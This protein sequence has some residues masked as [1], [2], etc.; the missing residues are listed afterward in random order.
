MAKNPYDAE[1]LNDLLLQM[2]ETELGGE[3]VYLT[4]LRCA[5]NSDLQ[6]EWQ[7]YLEQTKM[8]Q[9]V[10]K[11]LCEGVGLDPNTQT[12]SRKVVKHIGD[13]LVQAME[14]ALQG[15]SP[16]AAELVACECVVHAETKDHANWELLGKVVKVASG[17][18]GKLLKDA[19]D[20]VEKEED[21]HLYHTKGWC[22]ELWIQ[23]LGMPAVLPPPE[24]VKQVESAVGAARAEQQRDNLL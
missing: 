18:V 4:A 24:E 5:Q 15:G 23:S 16:A 2:M 19:F 21:H 17:D 22:R 7:E 14:L 9:R 20:R 6:E 1:Q 10:V 8:H 12:P 13:S 3:Q 11:A